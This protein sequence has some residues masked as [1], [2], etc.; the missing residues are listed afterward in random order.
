M[1][2][3]DVPAWVAIAASIGAIVV[4]VQARGDGKQAANSAAESVQ[5]ARESLALQ[6]ELA[7]E[8]R[9]AAAPYV[10]LVIDHVSGSRYRLRNAGTMVAQDVHIINCGDWPYLFN[11]QHD[12]VVLAAEESRELRMSGASGKPIPSQL[13]VTWDGQD[14]LVPVPV[15]AV[16]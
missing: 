10:R 5:V 1:D 7:E 9:A 13:W 6:Q 14:E 4:S 16:G 15:P 2:W 3:G 11:W 12:G 8:Q